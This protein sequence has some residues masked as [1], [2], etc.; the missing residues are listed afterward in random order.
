MYDG[1]GVAVWTSGLPKIISDKQFY[2]LW[3]GAGY[4]DIDIVDSTISP[5]SAQVKVAQHLTTTLPTITINRAERCGC[6]NQ[7]GTVYLTNNS[8][9]PAQ[10]DINHIYKYQGQT[11][12]VD[13]FKLNGKQTIKIGCTQHFCTKL[14]PYGY[15]EEYRLRFFKL[16]S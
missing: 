15:Y 7:G 11:L 4:F 3:N 2:Q 6:T 9:L 13:H 8:L 12:E 1:L 14:A 5:V 10:I 16:G